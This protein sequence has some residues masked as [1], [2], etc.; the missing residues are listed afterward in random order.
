[1]TRVRTQDA[2]GG[3][4]ENEM[5]SF[6]DGQA[7]PSYRQATADLAVREQGDV[8]TERPQPG[9]QAISPKGSALRRFSAGTAVPINVPARP[10]EPDV[11]R[12]SALIGA[13]VPFRQVWFL[14]GGVT[15]PCEK[16]SLMGAP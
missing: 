8:A 10:L 15:E 13:V 3:G 7:D 4:A 16:T 9:N 14:F 6:D 11:A 5:L 12:N 2:D 1:M